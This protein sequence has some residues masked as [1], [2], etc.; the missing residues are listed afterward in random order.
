M[1]EK[2]PF[3]PLSEAGFTLVNFQE[4]PAM[5]IGPDSRCI[6]VEGQPCM[7]VDKRDGQR[8]A[9]DHLRKIDREAV[10]RRGWQ[11]G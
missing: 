3:C 7:D 11:S 5:V 4:L 2:Y 6:C 1:T 10:I 9:L 8:C